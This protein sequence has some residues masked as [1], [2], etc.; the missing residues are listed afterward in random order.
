MMMIVTVAITLCN[1]K[2]I[3]LI[4]GVRTESTSTTL[5]NREPTLF[6][7]FVLSPN[8]M[9][10]TFIIKRGKRVL[11]TGRALPGTIA[12]YVCSVHYTKYCLRRISLPEKEITANALIKDS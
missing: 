12:Y 2:G 8:A 4:T 9:F 11:Q 5:M 10:S 7:Q 6:P 3:Q 1:S